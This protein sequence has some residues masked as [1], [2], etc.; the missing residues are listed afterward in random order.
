MA[1]G[2]DGETGWAIPSAD[3][4][5][6]D[7]AHFDA[8]EASSILDLIEHELAP[9]FFARDEGLPRARGLADDNEVLATPARAAAARDA[10]AA[11]RRRAALHAH[12]GLGAELALESEARSL[13]DAHF[14]GCGEPPR[15]P[16]SSAE[17]GALL[18]A[19]DREHLV[20]DARLRARSARSS[21]SGPRP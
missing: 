1:R 17:R 5:G 6:L 8:R 19:E 16:A 2:Y 3:E 11:R 4:A 21:A 9:L 20:L 13:P 10:H 12:R 15:R 18:R 7:A 14:R